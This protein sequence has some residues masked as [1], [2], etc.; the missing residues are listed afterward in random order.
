M[1]EKNPCT[2]SEVEQNV[3]EVEQISKIIYKDLGISFGYTCSYTNILK[4]VRLRLFLQVTSIPGLCPNRLFLPRK[5]SQIFLSFRV[6]F[7]VVV[8]SRRVSPPQIKLF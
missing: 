4:N 3:H 6:S 5:L 7:V 2:C 8:Y 1:Y